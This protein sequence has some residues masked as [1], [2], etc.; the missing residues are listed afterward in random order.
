AHLP[1]RTRRRSL[2]NDVHQR[3]ALRHPS[4]LHPVI[5]PASVRHVGRQIRR[6]PPPHHPNANHLKHII[7]PDRAL[8]RPLPR[9]H[10]R[11]LGRMGSRSRMLLDAGHAALRPG[12]SDRLRPANRFWCGSDSAAVVD[13]DTSGRCEAGH[14]SCDLHEELRA[15]SGL[16]AGPCHFGYF[17][18]FCAA[19]F[20]GWHWHFWDGVSR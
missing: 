19:F 10:H 16:D 4:L 7:R 3:L 11:R 6:P 18:Q 2:L 12:K 9:E 5:L 13:S 20:F 14:G 17:G 8:D 1:Q 15:E